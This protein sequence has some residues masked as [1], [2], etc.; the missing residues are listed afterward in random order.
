MTTIGK[1]TKEQQIKSMKKTSRDI[2]LSLQVGWTAKN[3][4]HKSKK[5]YDRKNQ[6]KQYDT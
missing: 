5:T 3:K 4:V 6:K 2:E 1:I